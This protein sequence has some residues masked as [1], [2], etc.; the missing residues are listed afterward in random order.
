MRVTRARSRFGPTGTRRSSAAM[1]QRSRRAAV[2][3]VAVGVVTALL[4]ASPGSTVAMPSRLA[5]ETL[6]ATPVD[7]GGVLHTENN[8]A[9]D[10]DGSV[11]VGGADLGDRGGLAWAVDL[12]ETPVQARDLGSL[13]GGRA[14]GASAVDGDL[15]VGTS[16]MGGR[17]LRAFVYDLG[18][19]Q[20]VMRNLGSLGGVD[21]T[22]GAVDVDG[23]TVVG[24]S[25]TSEE[26]VEHV[27]AYDVNASTP[28][29]RDLGIAF[30]QD[31]DS[32]SVEGDIV[33]GSTAQPDGTVHAFAYDLADATP[34]VRDLGTLGGSNSVATAVD[35]SIVVGRAQ[36]AN[37]RWRAFAYDLDAAAPTMRSL[38]TLGGR[39]SD[40]VDVEDGTVVGSA[41]DVDGLSHAFAYDLA[42]PAPTMRDLGTVAGHPTTVVGVS[43]G[44]VAGSWSSDS[45]DSRG[46]FVADLAAPTPELVE[47]APAVPGSEVV[48]ADGIGGNVVTGSY[49]EA[50][51]DAQAMA[52][53]VSRTSAPAFR[54]SRSTTAVEE[55]AG[56][57]TVTVT[58]AGDPDP[59]VSVDYA[60]GSD[61]ATD[62]ADAGSTVGTVTFAAG[63]T[64]RSFTVPVVNDSEAEEAEILLLRL[65]NPTGGAVLGEPRTAALRIL[66]SDQQPDLLLRARPDRRYRGDDIYNT[67]ADGQTRHRTARRNRTR[68]FYARITTDGSSYNHFTVRAAPPRRGSR[69]RYL[70]EGQDVTDVLRSAEGMGNFTRPGVNYRRVE[71]RI[72]VGRYAR[73]GSWKPA[74]LTATWTGDGTLRD[75]VKA[76]VHVIR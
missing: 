1:P 23:G 66:Q 39:H 53:V 59:V 14:G 45:G 29:M 2:V 25:S 47:L 21:G 50:G 31:P 44:V 60:T 48:W 63:E 32:L 76:N 22:S 42:D 52:W 19:A 68:I 27:F 8:T 12:S 30:Q 24:W 15:V 11:V 74:T 55:D 13:G 46:A 3:A 65:S 67:T 43:D 38:G 62:G 54:F 26:G 6:V 73:I 37:G 64:E 20:P 18:A 33:A 58:R 36:R 34:T 75:T 16:D 49:S 5:V 69:I 70:T 57:A 4:L 10:V 9:S 7:I 40:A 72:T 71:I 41:T 17:R 56:V 35:G 61:T 51:G 28:R